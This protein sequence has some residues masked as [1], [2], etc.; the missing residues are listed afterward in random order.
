MVPNGPDRS[1][2]LSR[3]ELAFL[4][5]IHYRLV[6][7]LVSLD[8]IEPAESVPEPV[9]Y[10][11]VVP[12]VRRLIELHTQLGVSWTSMEF[13]LTLMERIE[14]LESHQH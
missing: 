13:V 6:D 12:R 7:R 8:L 11:D 5:G 9:F 14:V 3:E 1:E 2:L 4:A 10:A